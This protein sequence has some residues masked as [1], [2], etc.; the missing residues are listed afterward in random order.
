MAGEEVRALVASTMWMARLRGGHVQPI[1]LGFALDP[2]GFAQHTRRKFL[3]TIPE[4]RARAE[5]VRL[6]AAIK[7]QSNF[8]GFRLRKIVREMMKPKK[9]R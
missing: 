8:R 1:E 9:T 6:D 2:E 4:S 5:Q 7:I 3:T